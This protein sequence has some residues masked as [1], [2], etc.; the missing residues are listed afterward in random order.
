MRTQDQEAQRLIRL[1][2]LNDP[3]YVEFR[4][5]WIGILQMAQRHDS[6]LYHQ[7]M[8]FPPDLPDLSKLRPPGGNARSQGIQESYF[9]RRAEGS[10]PAAY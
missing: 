8:G 3:E 2:G 6:A 7:L 1:L 4:C 9:R 5:L 10:L